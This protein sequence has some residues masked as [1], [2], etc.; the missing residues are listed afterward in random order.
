MNIFLK[1]VTPAPLLGVTDLKTE[2][3]DKEITFIAGKRYKIHATSG[4]GKSTFLHSIYGL[5]DDYEGEI[6]IQEKSTKTFSINEWA[7]LRANS[8]SIIFQDLR[9]FPELTGIENINVK[10]AL[11][12]HTSIKEV[13]EMME[14]LQITHI[15]NKKAHTMSYGERQRIAIIR[16]LVSPFSWLLWDEP[17]SHLDEENTKRAC[18]LITSVCNKNKAGMLMTS[19]GP[20][21]NLIFDQTVQL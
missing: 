4:K 7:N 3:W 13:E 10:M 17:F 20:D 21:Y 12:Q 18:E 9:L 5:R 19:L 2:I 16:S 15:A 14:L 6:F 1:N 8:L 11:N